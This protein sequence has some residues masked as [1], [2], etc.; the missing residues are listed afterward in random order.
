M[1]PEEHALIQERLERL[2]KIQK[3]AKQFLPLIERLFDDGVRK[4]QRNLKR[5]PRKWLVTGRLGSLDRIW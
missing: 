2:A 5:R 1:T 3:R 4:T